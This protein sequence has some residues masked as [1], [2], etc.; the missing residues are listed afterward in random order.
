[1]LATIAM[2]WLINF[3]SSFNSVSVACRFSAMALKS[4]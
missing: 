1:V 3:S 2:T 4:A